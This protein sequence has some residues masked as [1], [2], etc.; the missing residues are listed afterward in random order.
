MTTMTILP[1][2][3]AY[4]LTVGDPSPRPAAMP[5]T[6]F[7][8]EM[9]QAAVGGARMISCPQ[10]EV[11]VVKF[12]HKG[13]MYIMAASTTENGAIVFVY[14]PNPDD[15]D[16]PPTEIGFGHVDPAKPD[17]IP[18]LR[19]EPFSVEKHG[20]VCVDLFPERV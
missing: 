6:T 8:G 3:L 11:F 12:K 17:V 19:W 7:S 10:G 14:D 2:A 18:P 1:L 16:S 4:I 9:T 13:G 5:W 15:R 20:S